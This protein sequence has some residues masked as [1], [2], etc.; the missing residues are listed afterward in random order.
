MVTV[1]LGT[2]NRNWEQAQTVWKSEVE[3][4]LGTKRNLD[5][6]LKPWT[7]S[8]D[9]AWGSLLWLAFEYTC[10]VSESQ[11]E[12]ISYEFCEVLYIPLE[13]NKVSLRTLVSLSSSEG[14]HRKTYQEVLS[15]SLPP[16]WTPAWLSVSSPLHFPGG[17]VLPR[18]SRYVCTCLHAWCRPWG[19]DCGKGGG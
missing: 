17:A 15:S 16:E 11:E 19:K 1:P 12:V 7:R 14:S 10:R 3:M 4:K 2:K 5:G 18:L 13:L 9:Q 6:G 8:L